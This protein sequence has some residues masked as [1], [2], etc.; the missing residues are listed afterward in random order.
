MATTLVVNGTSYA[1]PNTGDQQWGSAATTWAIAVTN[2]MLQKAG[3]NFTLT[4]DVNFGPTYG[5]LS[6]YFTSIS[7]NPATTGAVRFASGDFLAFRNNANTADLALGK[8]SSDQLTYNG[9]PVS[10][11]AINVKL[12]PYN[13]T[14]NGSTDDTTAIQAA[15]TAVP[16]GG[17][18]VYF[19]AGT[20]II[21]SPL[22]LK[23]NTLVLGEGAASVLT[24]ANGHLASNELGFITGTD[25]SNVRIC[26]MKFNGA[27]S[28]TSTPF[29]NPYASGNSVGFTNNDIGVKLVHSS[30]G[31]NNVIVEDCEFTGLGYGVYLAGGGTD[32]I[33]EVRGNYFHNLGTAGCSA[34]LCSMLKVLGNTVSG[35]FGNLTTAGDTT[36]ADSSTADGMYFGSCTDYVCNNNYVYNFIRCG[37]IIE[38]DGTVNSTRIAICGN[39]ISTGQAPR[40]GQDAAGIYI[41]DGYTVSP[42]QVADNVINN[43]APSNGGVGIYA[44]IGCNITGGA[45]TGCQ[46]GLGLISGPMTVTGVDLQANGYGIQISS[47]AS[48]S[49]KIK[50]CNIS[51]NTISGIL[52]YQSKG[53]FDIQ[54]NTFEDNGSAAGS[55]IGNWSAI[56]ID[57]EYNAQTVLIRGN[58]FISSAN[59]S[60]TAGQLYSIFVY[61]GGDFSRS[62]QWIQNNAFIFTGTFSDAYPANLAVGPV[63]FAYNNTST[64]YLYEIV[65]SSG[66]LNSK[67]PNPTVNQ[68]AGAGGG[69]P[70]FLGYATTTP[71]SGT[72]ATGDYFMNRSLT[73]GAKFI[74]VC[75]S[76]GTPGTWQSLTLS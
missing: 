4:A 58:A 18:T 17:G 76:G 64:T 48:G 45:V 55:A 34:F 72:Y 21:S 69:F 52:I 36:V 61:G 54:D 25:V 7:V 67:A 39:N 57:R 38:P 51:L 27:G 41:G 70:R 8:N 68:D 47:W 5:L 31:F 49:C 23:S 1:Y 10:I 32:S 6:T 42:I 66:N 20:Y 3:G 63:S 53:V 56:S 35:V 19:P 26:K 62:T 12:Q 74:F 50:T 13:A 24:T 60:A 65:N 37:I 16:S 40:G 75:V 11:P 33:I 28:W 59:E 14:G 71:V 30:T 43:I 2:G 44:Q 29:A 73:S 22:N 46:I 15:L 9:Y